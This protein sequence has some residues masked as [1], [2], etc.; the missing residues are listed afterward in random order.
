[1]KFHASS[2][3]HR[4]PNTRAKSP[5]PSKGSSVRLVAAAKLGKQPQNLKVQPNQR[6]HNPERTVP[7][8]VFGSAHAR[9]ILDKVEI[10]HQVERGD[11]YDNQ[12]EAD[13]D[14]P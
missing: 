6:D 5:Y 7:L 12:T 8:H 14:G 1:M 4:F 11:A 10:E 2:K 3:A 13:A 9:A